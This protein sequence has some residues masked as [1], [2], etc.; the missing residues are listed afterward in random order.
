MGSRVAW[1]G[2]FSS[3]AITQPAAGTF[4]SGGTLGVHRGQGEAG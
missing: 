4:L 3:R 2:G 1:A